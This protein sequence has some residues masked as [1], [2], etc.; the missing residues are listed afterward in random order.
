M[1][2]SQRRHFDRAFIEL[3]DLLKGHDNHRQNCERWKDRKTSKQI[4]FERKLSI[5]KALRQMSSKCGADKGA[6]QK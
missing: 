2:T 3:R 1:L 5:I 6:V 4:I